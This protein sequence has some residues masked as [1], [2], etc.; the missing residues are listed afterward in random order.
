ML[1]G[2]LFV[3]STVIIAY[4]VKMV[5]S[6][7]SNKLREGFEESSAEAQEGGASEYYGW[8]YHPILDKQR[9]QQQ[10]RRKKQKKE[11]KCIDEVVLE[12]KT[13]CQKMGKCPI[14]S[15][16]D[17]DKYVLRSSIKPCA[18]L[19]DY[20]K[21]SMLCPSIDMEKY[22]LRSK[23]RPNKCPDLTDYIKKSEISS[24][25]ECGIIK[26]VIRGVPERIVRRR[27]MESYQKGRREALQELREERRVH[28][29]EKSLLDDIFAPFKKIGSSLKFSEPTYSGTSF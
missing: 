25:P 24:S 7:L 9:K 15:H 11:E 23:C 6:K 10:R 13:L 19:R 2:I 8:G 27:E 4:I 22:M 26:E 28:R 12:R 21:K 17:I 20:T 14:T 16:P 5:S 29:E 3:L 1:F 18:D